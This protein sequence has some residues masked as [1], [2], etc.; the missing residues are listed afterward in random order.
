MQRFLI[1]AYRFRTCNTTGA[2][3]GL[4]TTANDV[5]HAFV[6]IITRHYGYCERF[7][8][9]YQ[10]VWQPIVQR[11]TKQRIYLSKSTRFYKCWTSRKSQNCFLIHCKRD[12]WHCPKIKRKKIKMIPSQEN[13]SNYAGGTCCPSIWK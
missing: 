3:P 8:R 1:L 4:R 7:R 9:C 13:T 10:E 2:R 5:E 6:P 12:S 11:T